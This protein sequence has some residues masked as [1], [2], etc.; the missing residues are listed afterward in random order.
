MASSQSCSRSS[1]TSR[2]GNQDSDSL[3]TLS[4]AVCSP[5][6]AIVYDTGIMLSYHHIS[7]SPISTARSSSTSYSAVLKLTKANHPQ[8]RDLDAPPHHSHSHLA[9]AAKR[10]MI[11][12]SH[13]WDPHSF[14]AGSE[15]PPSPMTMQASWS[16]PSQE[17][18]FSI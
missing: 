18:F 7:C 1:T 6:R 15:A 3:H 16:S 17:K 11:V 12:T 8:P 9:S 5:L 10:T 4:S 13:I 14:I 2:R